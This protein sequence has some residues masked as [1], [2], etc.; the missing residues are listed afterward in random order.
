MEKTEFEDIYK[1]L[2]REVSQEIRETKLEIKALEKEALTGD[3]E[4]VKVYARFVN[5]YIKLNELLLK[6]IVDYV[7]VLEGE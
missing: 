6:L 4:N 1:E 3:K 5:Q 2:I 7:K